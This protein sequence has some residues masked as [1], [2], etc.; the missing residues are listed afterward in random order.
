[1][2]SHIAISV[3]LDIEE[4]VLI[5]FQLAAVP[6]WLGGTIAIF[7]ALYALSLGLWGLFSSWP[8]RHAIIVSLLSLLMI[9]FLIVNII[10]AAKNKG[11]CI[12]RFE[13]DD[14][15]EVRNSFLNN[16]AF[17]N[18]RNATFVRHRWCGSED[19]VYITHGILLGLFVSIILLICILQLLNF[20]L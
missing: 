19:A 12:P 18:N 8:R 1:L 9:A 2:N 13:D 7:V 14:D 11:L 5:S 10:L 17:N 3:L 6:A 15:N 4:V 20:Q 16:D